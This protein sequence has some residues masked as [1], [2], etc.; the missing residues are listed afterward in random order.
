MIRAP[1]LCGGGGLG[2][3]LDAWL[4]PNP[5]A[6]ADR[7]RP[8]GPQ[9]M[10]GKTMLLTELTKTPSAALP[11]AALKDHLRLGTAFGLDGLQDGLIETHLRAAIATI[12]GRLG[13]VLQRRSY[14]LTLAD[15][16]D[17]AV[18]PLPLAPA[19][20]VARVSMFDAMGVEMV[21]DSTRYRLEADSHRPKLHAVGMLFPAAPSDGRIEIL[22]DAG[23]GD[24]WAQVP[25]DL[26][27]AVMLLAA[28]LYETRHDAG[29]QAQIMGL[30]A[31][32]QS[33]IAPWRNVRVLGGGARR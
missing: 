21:L 1:A 3:R 7:A 17:N 20:A 11:L 30:P 28:Q 18:Q 32:V 12:E 2:A 5:P 9:A 4:H 23:F 26:A 13:K 19:L 14:K 27:Q 25:A 16:R 33:L 31:A 10:K 24:T 29:A 6:Q 15:W 8:F 22:F